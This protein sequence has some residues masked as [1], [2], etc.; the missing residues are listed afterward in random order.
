MD[1]FRKTYQNIITELISVCPQYKGN[2]PKLTEL[3]FSVIFTSHAY[4]HDAD[5]NFTQG[6]E[7]WLYDLIDEQISKIILSKKYKDTIRVS[8]FAKYDDLCQIPI[9]ID[10]T[11]KKV[12]LLTIIPTLSK[13]RFERLSSM[14]SFID[15][16]GNLNISVRC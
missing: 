14:A 5:R 9:E 13:Q 11:S 10:F 3:E 1:L 2:F 15:S 12:I 8:L 16:K 7:K 4:E 6:N